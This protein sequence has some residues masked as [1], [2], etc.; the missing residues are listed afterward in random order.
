GSRRVGEAGRAVP[1]GA[2]VARE[3]MVQER[4]D[5]DDERVEKRPQE[6]Q[7]PGTNRARRPL[8]QDR[9]PNK[10]RPYHNLPPSPPR[11]RCRSLVLALIPLARVRASPCEYGLGVRPSPRTAPGLNPGGAPLVLG[12]GQSCPPAFAARRRAG[13]RGEWRARFGR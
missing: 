1:G 10:L 3:V 8:S 6:H 5:E 4:G 7:A 13:D 11:G 9:A 2:V 12:T